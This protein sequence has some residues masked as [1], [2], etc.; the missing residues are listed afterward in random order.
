MDLTIPAFRILQSSF[1]M[2][3]NGGSLMIY[4]VED[5]PNIR[6]LIIYTLKGSGFEARG[7]EDAAL[8]RTALRDSYPELILLDIMLP[9]EDGLSVLADLKSD[10]KTKVIPVILVTAKGSEYDKVMGLDSGADDYIAKPFGM[11]EFVSRVKAVL[12]RTNR[13]NGEPRQILSCGSLRLDT[14]RHTV[15]A[16]GREIVLTYKEF[17]LLRYLLN[18]RGIVVSRDALLSSIWGYDFDGETRTV[19]LRR[20]FLALLRNVHE[21]EK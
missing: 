3:W 1:I 13:K 11:M 15:T 18:N 4:C 5:D 8:F 6:D 12:R 16:D 20:L 7:F 10:P 14:G 19:S 9:G 2:N 21:S 17:E